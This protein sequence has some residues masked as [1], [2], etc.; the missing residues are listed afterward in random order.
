MNG[1]AQQR[2]YDAQATGMAA[3]YL[4]EIGI[5]SEGTIGSST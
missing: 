2:Q 5:D 3:R 4:V 1:Q